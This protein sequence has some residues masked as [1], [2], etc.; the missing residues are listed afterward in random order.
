M[1][2]NIKAVPLSLKEASAFIDELHRHHVPSKGDKFRVGA[3]V[4]GVLVGVV[5]VG[6]P[7][8]RYLDDGETLEVTR[9]CTDGTENVCSFLYSRAARI[10]KEMGYRKII[11]YILD[12]ESGTSLKASGWFLEDDNCG[13]G[14]WDCPSRRRTLMPDQISMFPQ[15]QKYATNKKQRWAKW[16]VKEQE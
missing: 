7:V 2:A 14:S 4:G 16:L 5:Q 6:R 10:A 15:K 9:L 3:S 11:T 8:S 12:S 13:G 1:G